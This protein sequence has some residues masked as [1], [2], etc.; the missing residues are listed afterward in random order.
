MIQPR[1]MSDSHLDVQ[2]GALVA[3][4]TRHRHLISAH[5]VA[6]ATNRAAEEAAAV[7]NRADGEVLQRGEG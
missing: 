1:Q 7:K 2:R 3:D 4:A 6:V 5:F